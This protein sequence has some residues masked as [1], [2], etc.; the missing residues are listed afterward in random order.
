MAYLD[1]EPG[2]TLLRYVFWAFA[3]CITA[4]RYCTLMIS[5]NGTH[6]YGKYRRVLMTAMAT[7][8]NQKVFPL[9]FAVVDNKSGPS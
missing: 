3:P 6:L 8:A 2:I 1:Q 9:A 5:I 4:F 7:D